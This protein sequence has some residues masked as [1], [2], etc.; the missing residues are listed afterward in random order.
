MI[1]EKQKAFTLAEVL[2][3]ITIIGVIASIVIPTVINNT[4]NAELKATWKKAYADL[5][6]ATQRVITDNAGTLKGDVCY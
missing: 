6:Q 1:L 4:Q 2:I 5:S 3:T